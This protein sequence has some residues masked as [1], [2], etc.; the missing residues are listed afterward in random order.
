MSNDQAVM[1]AESFHGKATNGSQH[2][3]YGCSAGG[4]SGS[5][6]EV[7]PEWN[8]TWTGDIAGFSPRVDYNVN[9]TS[10]GTFRVWI[11]GDN[12]TSPAGGGDSCWAGVDGALASNY[13]AFPENSGAWAWAA[14]TMTVSTTGIHTLSVWA[15]DDGFRMDKIV[16]NKSTTPP[17]GNG[18]AVPSDA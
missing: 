14:Q 16:V 15:R 9:F 11:R 3:W 17:S 8:Y 1:E 5:C 10:T 12:G 4:I 7:G 13:H 2:S 18:P 6:M